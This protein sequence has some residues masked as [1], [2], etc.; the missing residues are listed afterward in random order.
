[1]KKDNSHPPNRWD[2]R[3]RAEERLKKG[4]LTPDQTT[5]AAELQRLLHE[6]SVHQIELE[7][8]N[9]GLQHAYDEI[10]QEHKR[11]SDLYDFAPVGYLTLDRE[12]RILEANIT[13]TRM[14]FC[15]RSHLKG[16]RLGCFIAQRDLPGFNSM[17]HR[18]FQSRR[19]EHCE[20]MIGCI[21]YRLDAIISDNQQ[22]CRLTL[23][24]VSDT[25]RA[26]ETLKNK[27]AIIGQLAMHDPLTGL[28]N[29]RLISERVS[30]TL[31]QCR[32]NKVMAALM[33]FDLDKFKTVNDTLGHAIGDTLLQQVAA[34]SLATLQ[35]SG[36]SITRLGDDEFVVLLPQIDAL[37]NAVTMAEKIRQTIKES[38][39]IEG[40]T[41]DIS[42]S[43]GIA[44]IPD[45]GED[46]LTLMKHA[47]DAMY[48]AKNQGR[49]NVTVYVKTASH[50]LH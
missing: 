50:A 9:E 25:R 46:E 48:S 49:D 27:E 24:D 8:Q 32:R 47:D 22:K 37:A 35:R 7:M 30:L 2:L 43:I 38:Y 6:L 26:L 45:H 42:C 13:I 17:I 33:I 15:R 31:A 18:V 1:M 4:G 40:H 36:D 41:I 19:L 14:L 28:P 5:S 16:S 10:R 20:I 29:R 39:I 34:R 44:V 12:S 21:A 3:L 23:T 11:Y